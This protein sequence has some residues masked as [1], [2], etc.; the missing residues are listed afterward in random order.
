MMHLTVMRR[1]LPILAASGH[2]HYTKYLHLYLQ[3]MDHLEEQHPEV[4]QHF[5]Q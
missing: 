5:L 3:R 4:Y 1:I 2:D